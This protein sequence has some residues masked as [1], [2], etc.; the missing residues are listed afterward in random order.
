MACLSSTDSGLTEAICKRW[1]NVSDEAK[2]KKQRV[3]KGKE[4]KKEE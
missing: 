2:L 4:E 3:K 1:Q